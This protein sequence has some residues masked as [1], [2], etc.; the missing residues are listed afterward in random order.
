MGQRSRGVYIQL[1]GLS[2]PLELAYRIVALIITV[3]AAWGL[4]RLLSLIPGVRYLSGA[5][6]R[7]DSGT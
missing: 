1:A 7:W 5:D 3:A 6:V 4:V 2:L